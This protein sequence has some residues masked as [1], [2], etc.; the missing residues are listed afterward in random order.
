MA[1][2]EFRSQHFVLFGFLQCVWAKKRSFTFSLA[3]VYSSYLFLNLLQPDGT[4]LFCFVDG[5][6][7][8]DDY[9]SKMEQG[10]T[11]GDHVILRAAANCYETCIHV[12]S[13]LPHGNDVIIRPDC[14]VVNRK[15]LVLGHVH[16]IHYVSLLPI[17][18]K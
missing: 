18:G 13:S 12:V 14:H 9:L 8:W 17:Q 6:Q 4:D 15:P 1:R 3:L 7:S 10:G 16:E 11:W 2:G 5:Y